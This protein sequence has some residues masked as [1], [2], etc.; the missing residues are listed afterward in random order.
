MIPL[1]IVAT[2]QKR[3]RARLVARSR[4]Q[5]LDGDIKK[6]CRHRARRPK[7][8]PS[9]TSVES[10]RNGA[11]RTSIKTAMLAAGPSAGPVFHGQASNPTE[12]AFVVR[13]ERELARHR[14]RC[15]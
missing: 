10:W 13:N 6:D 1:S 3:F 9:A 15:D 4:L 12:L 8:G 11:S 5:A 7:R 14:L 2:E